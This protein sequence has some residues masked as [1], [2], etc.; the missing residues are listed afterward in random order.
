WIA[1]GG[2]GID[3][4]DRIW[5]RK[6]HERVVIECAGTIDQAGQ[7]ELAGGNGDGQCRA[8]HGHEQGGEQHETFRNGRG[9]ELLHV[10]L[11]FSGAHSRASPARGCGPYQRSVQF[12]FY[13]VAR[14]VLRRARPTSPTTPVPNR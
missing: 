14:N 2:K 11:P 7:V 12:D 10:N 1:A 13:V 5:T 8:A 4:G 9:P 3:L 6:V